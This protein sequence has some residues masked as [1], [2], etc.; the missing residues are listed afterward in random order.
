MSL[1]K[2]LDRAIRE[3]N[4]RVIATLCPNCGGTG[5]FYTPPEDGSTSWTKHP[6]KRCKGTG[7]R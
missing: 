5:R 2:Q 1:S 3:E 6:C 7:D 4:A